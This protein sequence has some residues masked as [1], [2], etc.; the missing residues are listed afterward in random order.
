MKRD[1]K[2]KMKRVDSICLRSFV[3]L[4]AATLKRTCAQNPPY[5]SVNLGAWLVAEGWM[6]PDLFNGI[7][8][9]DLL[10]GSQVQIKSTSLNMYLCAESGGGSILVA[11]RTAA[12][13]WET[14]RLWRIDERTFNFR[15]FN[16]DFIGIMG[17]TAIAQAAQPGS[18]ETFVIVRNGTDPLR[19][20]I[21]APNGLY[22]QA[23]S[24]NSVTA[25]YGGNPNDWG[26]QNPSV[27]KLTIVNTLQGE[28]QLT[29]G[30]GPAQAPAVMMN[31]WST[32]IVAD[33]FRFMSQNGLTAVRIPVGWWIMYDPAPKPFVAGS[34]HALDNAFTWA[35]QYN[36]KVIVDLHAAPGSQNGNDH[37]GTR[38]GYQEWGASYI[39]QTVAVIDFLAKRYGNRLGLAAIELMNEP[40]AP[41][42]SLDDLSNYYRAGYNAVR[43][44][45]SSAYVILSNRLGDASNTELLPLAGGL[46]L[47]VIDVHYYNLYWD[48]FTTL[49]VEQNIDYI[50]NQRANSLQ[51]VTQTNGPLS[52]VGEWTG[53]WAVQNAGAQDYQRYA[54]AQLNV[55]GR[56]SFGWA[57]WSYKCQYN[58]WSL[59]WMIQNNYIK[60]Q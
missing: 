52:F 19:I 56:A 26:D 13:G 57:Y 40:L 27:F 28:Y 32:Y 55:Y 54:S 6:T 50:N 31:H 21:L 41:G 18:T 4:C 53:E 42:V 35:E 15:V 36:M 29:N 44:H 37:S 9:K 8:N 45:T 2:T 1:L 48:Y 23:L 17:G 47:L 60:L 16:K 12:S 33:D 11:N 51:Q 10:D 25:D 34:L 58:H 46:S 20:R 30:Y 14:F 49:N 43:K 7:P 39:P 59:E 3:I 24:G 38:D 22:F 5:K